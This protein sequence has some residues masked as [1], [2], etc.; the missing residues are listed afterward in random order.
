MGAVPR[1][2]SVT[3]SGFTLAVYNLGSSAATWTGLY[4]TWKAEV[5]V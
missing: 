5:D 3:T 2:L 1:G 4:V